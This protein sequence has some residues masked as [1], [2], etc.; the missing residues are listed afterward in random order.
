[1]FSNLQESWPKG[2]H[3]ATVF[4]VTCF[5]NNSWSI[6]QNVPLLPPN[7]R[8]LSTLLYAAIE[9]YFSNSGAGRPWDVMWRHRGRIWPPE[10]RYTS[11]I[12]INNGLTCSKWGCEIFSFPQGGGA[13]NKQLRSTDRIIKVY[14]H[15]PWAFCDGK[16]QHTLFVNSNSNLRSCACPPTLIKCIHVRI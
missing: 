11:R 10:N 13:C 16:H 3:V 5:S 12:Y 15:F 4:S 14:L 6:G 1:M 9:L 7:R 2:N 8:C